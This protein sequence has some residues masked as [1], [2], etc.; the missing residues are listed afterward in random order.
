MSCLQL[1]FD[2]GRMLRRMDAAYNLPNL[3]GELR[4]A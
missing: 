3:H 4:R 2:M 1:R